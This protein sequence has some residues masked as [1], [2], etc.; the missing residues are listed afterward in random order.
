[1][2][3][4]TE[5]AGETRLDPPMLSHREHRRLGDRLFQAARDS[6][7]VEPL[8]RRY[9]EL[10]AADACAIRDQ[11]VAR[12]L[13]SGERL[14][15]AKA[16]I[17]GETG[18][19]G[20]G[21]R[22]AWLTDAMLLAEHTVAT[23]DQGFALVEPK[24]AVVVAQP[25]DRLDGASADVLASA[26]AICPCLEVLSRGPAA[27]RVGRLHALALNAGAWCI[28]I[29]AG[30]PFAAGDS[31]RGCRAEIDLDGVKRESAVLPAVADALSWL[32]DACRSGAPRLLR[33]HAAAASTI[34]ISPAVTAP[35]SLEPERRMSVRFTGLGAVELRVV[36]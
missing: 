9:P 11:L 20:V 6:T 25:I 34:L 4:R 26:R 16:W 5:S 19:P 10:N 21:A 27:M 14:L 32:V 33:N 12:R 3:E 8:T 1:M 22:L 15:G 7:A 29:G 18:L 23:A 36:A 35:I 17:D 2:A 30:R 28:L 13:A 31:L 24:L